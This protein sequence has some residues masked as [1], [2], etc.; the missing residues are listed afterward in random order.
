MNPNRKSVSLVVALLGAASALLVMLS[1]GIFLQG[2]AQR[3]LAE[4]ERVKIFDRSYPDL[5]TY[6]QEQELQLSGY[7]WI[8]E[9]AG[10]VHLPIERAMDLVVEEAREVVN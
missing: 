10:I 1:F 4:E 3:R 8:D 7:F 5:E 9:E 2:W 6:R